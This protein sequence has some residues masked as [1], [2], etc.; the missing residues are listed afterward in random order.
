[1]AEIGDLPKDIDLVEV[2]Q[3][4]EQLPLASESAAQILQAPDPN[5]NSSGFLYTFTA[6]DCD[7]MTPGDQACSNPIQQAIN[8]SRVNAPDD[9]TIYVES[10]VYEEN[11]DIGDCVN[12]QL[13]GVSGAPRQFLMG[14]WKSTEIIIL[15]CL[16]LL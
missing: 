11:L 14:T 15:H 16:D 9:G 1:M 2:D 4:G 7:P 3:N 5:F 10:G 12:F 8:F 6:V 13:M